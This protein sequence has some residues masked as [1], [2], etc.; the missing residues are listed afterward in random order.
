MSSTYEFK[1]AGKS[2]I[3]LDGNFL[4]I[5]RKGFINL[6]N[7]GLDGEKS[8]DITNISGVQLKKAGLTSGYLQ[9][10]YPGSQENK[11]G[12]FSATQDENTVMFVKKEQAMA[13][14]IKAYIEE[15]ISN[16]NSNNTTQPIVESKVDATEEIRKYKSLMDDGIINEE[17]FQEKKRQLLGL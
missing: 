1:G 17:E 10:I 7:H 2:I 12:V 6:M 13:L 9:F 16:R 5:K 8:I 15:I 3:T 14:E 11:G 4:R